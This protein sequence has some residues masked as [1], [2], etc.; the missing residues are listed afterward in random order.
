VAGRNA[1]PHGKRAKSGQLK[2]GVLRV[3]LLPELICRVPVLEHLENRHGFEILRPEQP[4]SLNMWILS[5]RTD[6]HELHEKLAKYRLHNGPPTFTPGPL[7]A[8]LDIARAYIDA[9]LAMADE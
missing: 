3:V 4:I 9:V 8:A 6:N 2:I 7:S 5:I 1:N